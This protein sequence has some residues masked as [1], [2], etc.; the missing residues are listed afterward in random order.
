MVQIKMEKTVK[1]Q[2]RVKLIEK[3]FFIGL[4]SL[5][6]LAYKSPAMLSLFLYEQP[7]ITISTVAASILTFSL[8]GHYLNKYSHKY[9]STAKK[10][11]EKLKDAKRMLIS[12]LD[13]NLVVVLK[14]I[15]KGD[16]R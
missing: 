3:I 4:L 13:P 1:W 14:E 16:L 11:E 7:L 9:E 5:A 6:F 10:L 2:Y 12:N 15:V 8:L